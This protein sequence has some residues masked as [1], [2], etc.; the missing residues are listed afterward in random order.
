MR[1]RHLAPLLALAAC[2]DHDGLAAGALAITVYGEDYIEESIPADAFVDGWSVTFS[3]FE[4]DVGNVHAHADHGGAE[5]RV[6]GFT[7][8]DLAAG[9]GGAGHPLATLDA[10]GGEY[11]HFGYALRDLDVAGAATDGAETITFA[12]QFPVI[13]GH[14]HC[15]TRTVDG[16][17]TPVE[18]TIHGD[19]LFYDDAV[20]VEPGVAFQAVADADAD[21]DGDVTA[22]E[23]AAVDLSTFERYQVGSLDID[24]LWAFITYQ[25]TTIG[26]VDGEG[27]CEDVEVLE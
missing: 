12:W 13:V 1:S 27:H 8:L 17:T 9:S 21:G 19:H 18:I 25:V 2:G 14:A 23:L 15:G 10:P 20:A 5:L 26:H 7:R 16:G 6:D 24:D 3:R 11:D 4:L 22:A